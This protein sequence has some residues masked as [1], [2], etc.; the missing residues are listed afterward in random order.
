MNKCDY[1]KAPIKVKFKLYCNN[2]C[3]AK[4]RNKNLTQEQIEKK[5]ESDL[6]YRDNLSKRMKEKRKA[7]DKIYAKERWKNTISDPIKLEDKKAY[8]KE[9]QFINY[10]ENKERILARRKF[11]RKKHKVL[12]K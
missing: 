12:E 8:D 9:W 5:R 1:C 3:K 6:R 11:L 2:S 7:K 4:Y 10:Q